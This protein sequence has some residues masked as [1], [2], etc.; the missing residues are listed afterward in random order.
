MDQ[1]FSFLKDSHKVTRRKYERVHLNLSVE[2][3]FL[4][5]TPTLEQQRKQSLDF[6][7]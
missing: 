3:P 1:R 5:M 7:T 4:R 6:T 2:K